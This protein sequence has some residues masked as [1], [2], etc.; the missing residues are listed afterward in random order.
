MKP[1]YKFFMPFAFAAALSGCGGNLLGFDDNKNDIRDD[2]EAYIDSLNFLTQMQ[3]NSMMQMAQVYQHI[4]KSDFYTKDGKV[5]EPVISDLRNEID[6]ASNCMVHAFG[7][8]RELFTSMVKSLR[9]RVA[10]NDPRSDK[11]KEFD[12]LAQTVY[13]NEIHFDGTEDT[14]FFTGQN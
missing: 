8:N 6:L 4:F 7:D 14:C 2:V 9:R 10:D 12:Q 13:Y 11:I 5:S 3:R 1:F